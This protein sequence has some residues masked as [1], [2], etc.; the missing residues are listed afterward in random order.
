M[1]R[2]RQPR[3][4]EGDYTE[5]VIEPETTPAAGPRYQAGLG[6]S[7]LSSSG[8]P[9]VTLP[10]ITITPGADLPWWFW[11]GVGLAGGYLAS[12][13]IGNRLTRHLKRLSRTFAPAG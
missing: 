10:T 9:P 4:F 5:H 3:T 13:M 2:R 1:T 11:L 6:Q 12:V 7:A 8:P